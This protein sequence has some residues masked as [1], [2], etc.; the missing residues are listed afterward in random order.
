[1]FGTIICSILGAVF[2]PIHRDF[3]KRLCEGDSVILHDDFFQPVSLFALKDL[4]R[5]GPGMAQVRSNAR[6]CGLLIPVSWRI[7]SNHGRKSSGA[8]VPEG[9]G[10]QNFHGRSS[11]TRKETD[12][13]SYGNPLP[14]EV[15]AIWL[16]FAASIRMGDQLVDGIRGAPDQGRQ[17][18]VILRLFVTRRLWEGRGSAGIR[19][20]TGPSPA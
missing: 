9:V 8:G 11:S 18:G 19:S 15:S 12:G 1:M 10:C 20:A 14:I 17:F 3:P 13:R 16:P 7:L 4:A 2:L 6:V 5:C